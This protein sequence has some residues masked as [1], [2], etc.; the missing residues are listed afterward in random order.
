[1]T[2]GL[3]ANLQRS[4]E[5]P[6]S[7][8]QL[9]SKLHVPRGD[10]SDPHPPFGEDVAPTRATELRD[11]QGTARGLVAIDLRREVDKLR[12]RLAAQREWH[13][14]YEAG[15]SR[16][17]LWLVKQEREERIA[18]SADIVRGLE[19]LSDGLDRI[20]ATV[21]EVMWCGSGAL[22]ETLRREALRRASPDPASQSAPAADAFAR[23]EMLR[24]LQQKQ[25]SALQTRVASLEDV[26]TSQQDVTQY[27][28]PSQVSILARLEALE[29]V[30]PEISED[31]VSRIDA[32]ACFQSNQTP[33]FMARV[34]ASGQLLQVLTV[35]ITKMDE[36]MEAL[37]QALEGCRQRCRQ[38]SP[39][40]LQALRDDHC[41]ALSK[42]AA[43]D[44]R[45]SKAEKLLLQVASRAREHKRSARQESG[46]PPEGAD[47]Q[48]E[49]Q[50]AT[51]SPPRRT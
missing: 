27:L 36:H 5:V 49:R 9:S 10:A 15:A 22:G 7:A 12:S 16:D 28:Q 41:E 42:L 40:A 6:S 38:V 46:L 44:A 17:L 37:E 14:S 39:E 4:L 1:M 45:L 19:A 43:Q 29:R 8:D 32:L 35:R 24:E 23:A 11:T 50:G 34:E 18:E 47:A 21:E 2:D 51:A 31:L 20:S 30:L 48:E 26:S 13:Q 33:E 3:D 25:V